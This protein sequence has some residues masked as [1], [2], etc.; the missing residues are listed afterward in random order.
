MF[1]SAS[2]KTLVLSLFRQLFRTAE[3]TFEGDERAI[4]FAH[5]KI[6]NEFKKNKADLDPISIQEHLRTGRDAEQ[7][8]RESVIQAEVKDD[9]RCIVKVRDEHVRSSMEMPVLAPGEC[10]KPFK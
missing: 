3:I 10:N 9:G 6:R 5:D 4:D 1:K 8:L 2:N 7:Y